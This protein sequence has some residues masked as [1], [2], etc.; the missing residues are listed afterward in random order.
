MKTRSLQPVTPSLLKRL[1]CYLSVWALLMIS[2][3]PLLANAQAKPA[4]NPESDWVGSS[5]KMLK[6]F[7]GEYMQHQN[8]MHQIRM[9]GASMAQG[10]NLPAPQFGASAKYF[11]HCK[12]PPQ[13]A[14]VPNGQ[15]D[16][17]SSPGHANM[18]KHMAGQ[19]KAHAD[20]HE[21]LMAKGV[22]DPYPHGITC[23][24]NG[25]KKQ[26][27]AI[28]N[29]LNQLKMFEGTIA[30]QKQK[31]ENDAKPLLDAMKKLTQE[32]DGG[33]PKLVDHSQAFKGNGCPAVLPSGAIT[34]GAG[35]T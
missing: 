5:L 3:L 6:G 7:T 2:P 14:Q 25:L 17:A 11:P 10:S 22:S 16:E 1:T 32:L 13:S 23:L 35:L 20:F 12:L 34:P 28:Q 21:K 8:Q 27:D 31:F 19:A 18:M 9:Q 29:K 15:C 30:A 26:L 24:N 33:D 4:A